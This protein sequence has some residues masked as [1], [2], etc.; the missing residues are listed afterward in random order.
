MRNKILKIFILLLAF[1][2]IIACGD[3]EEKTPTPDVPTV[4]EPTP[5]EPTPDVPQIESIK[6][7]GTDT[8]KVGETVSFNAVV[9]PADAIGVIKWSVS[10]DELANISEEGVLTAK[11]EGSLLVI[12]EA[13]SVKCEHSVSILPKDKLEASIK[14]PSTITEGDSVTIE[15]ECN[16]GEEFEF[17]FHYFT[18]SASCYN[19]STAISCSWTNIY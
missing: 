10:S 16:Y 5:E 2:F 15:V 3:K 14:A 6:I 13:G 19:L 18:W 7:E 1:S 9:T 12:A 4:D 11:K 8:V 17:V